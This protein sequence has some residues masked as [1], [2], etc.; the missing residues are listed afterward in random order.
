MDVYVKYL[1]G[2]VEHIEDVE[3]VSWNSRMRSIDVIY[4]ERE[5][6]IAKGESDIYA[7]KTYK[8]KKILNFAAIESI[9]IVEEE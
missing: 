7:D 1:A 8:K 9:T 5:R 3:D 2:R 4:K 6:L